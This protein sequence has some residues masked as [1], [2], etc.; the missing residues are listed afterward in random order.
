[1]ANDGANAAYV[2]AGREVTF[3][4]AVRDASNGTAIFIVPSAAAQAVIPGD[5]FAVVECAPGETQLALGF[6][7]YRDNDLGDYNEALVV[8]FVRPARDPAAAEGT[9]IYALPVTQAFTCEAG[10]RI[11]GFPKSIEQVAISYEA[12]RATCRLTMQGELVFELSLPAAEAE[13]DLGEMDFVTYSYKD[14]PVA[15]PFRQGGATSFG[16][17][18]AV[19]LTLGQ[20]PIGAALAALGLPAVPALTTWTQRMYGSFGAPQPLR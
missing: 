13:D 10:R 16:D 20:H 14:V 19:R 12:E 4:V 11:W 6:V 9:F 8:F 3:P 15:T 18:S 5:A 17:P 2:I 1:M 7:D